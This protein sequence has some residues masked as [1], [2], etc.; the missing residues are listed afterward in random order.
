MANNDDDIIFDEGKARELVYFL[1]NND[2][3]VYKKFIPVIKGLDSEAFEN[4]F[5]GIP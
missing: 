1:L 3:I 2:A 4:L 5:Q